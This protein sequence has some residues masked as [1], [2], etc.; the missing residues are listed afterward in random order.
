MNEDT[1]A[2]HALRWR[3]HEGDHREL[4]GEVE[5]TGHRVILQQHARAVH[6]PQLDGF[7]SQQGLSGGVRGENRR[8]GYERR[9]V[10]ACQR[11]QRDDV[12]E[13][14][15]AESKQFPAQLERHDDTAVWRCRA[16]PH[17]NHQELR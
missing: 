15:D 13:K 1:A 11:R 4:P 5:P 7:A 10:A 16:R 14:F 12:E 8:E 6:R 17:A 9:R 3:R 2:I